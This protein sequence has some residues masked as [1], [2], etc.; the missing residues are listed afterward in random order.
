VLLL[1]D[2][3]V[4]SLIYDPARDKFSCRDFDGSKDLTLEEEP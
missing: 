4:A 2:G 3:R 1:P